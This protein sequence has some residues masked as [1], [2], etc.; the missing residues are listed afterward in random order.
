[1][2]RTNPGAHPRVQMVLTIDGPLMQVTVP[3]KGASMAGH[4]GAAVD[5]KMK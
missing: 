5:A 2:V 4:V 1:M 3:F